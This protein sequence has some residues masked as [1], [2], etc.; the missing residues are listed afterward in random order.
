MF[1]ELSAYFRGTLRDELSGQPII[2]KVSG[3]LFQNAAVTQLYLL[4]VPMCALNF[5]KPASR[6]SKAIFFMSLFLTVTSL[7]GMTA[8]PDA[9]GAAIYSAACAVNYNKWVKRPNHK[10]FA[11]SRPTKKQAC[12]FTWGA[13]NKKQAIAVALQRCQRFA[14]RGKIS[15]PKCQVLAVR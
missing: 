10:A 6:A 13:P 11:V 9:Y 7:N 12:G 5:L 1:A 8:A 14:A 4:R 3:C 15:K 2:L